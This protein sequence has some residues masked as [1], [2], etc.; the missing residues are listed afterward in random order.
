MTAPLAG[1]RVLEAANWLAAPAAAGLMADLGADVIK[2]EPPDGDAFRNVLRT[3]QP[4]AELH[5]AW[6]NDNR[7]KRGIAIDLEQAAGRALLQR[8][9]GGVDVFIT[10]LTRQRVTRYEVGFEVLRA[11]NPR[12][13]YVQFS[14]YG[15]RG[16]DADRP[17]FDY[18][19]FWARSGIEATI[20]EVSAPP[21]QP[22]GGQGDHT[23]SLNILAATLAALR[24]RDMTG[25][26]QR[27]EVTLQQTGLWTI[28]NQVQTALIDGEQPPQ[29]D[30]RA[31]RSPIA[32]TYPTRDGRWVQL[33]MPHAL[34]DW[35]A[36][37]RAIGE[38]QWIDEYDSFDKLTANAVELSRA[39][40]ERFL[41][42]DLAEW[43]PRLDAEGLLW[44]PVATLPEVIADPQLAAMDAFESVP[45]DRAGTL[46]ML[47]TPFQ[48]EGA[49]IR[50]RRRAPDVGEHTF[51]VLLEAGLSADEVAELAA[52]RVFG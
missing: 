21:I 3:S 30:R 34:R 18:L 28:S 39:I 50:V 17:G 35:P 4:E 26:A 43:A 25:E 37:A 20:G 22:V 6:E 47:R 31:P 45:H 29:F 5:P 1:V 40:E 49:D 41:R 15:S 27:V 36:F 24:L 32:N 12:L 11:V 16:P 13:V 23:T 8:L 10:N 19:A 44:A 46:R 52:Q 38:P 33:T 9:V 42:R 14:G 2:I 51:E 7:S 48:I